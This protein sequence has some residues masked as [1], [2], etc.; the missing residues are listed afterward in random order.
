MQP[1]SDKTEGKATGKFPLRL[2]SSVHTALSTISSAQEK[3]L[4]RKVEEILEAAMAG[5]LDLNEYK[6]PTHQ[7]QL[8]VSPDVIRRFVEFAKSLNRTVNGLARCAIESEIRR[9]PT[10]SISARLDALK[11]KHR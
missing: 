1:S 11:N 3:T 6:E 9:T 7:T 5:E 4:T 8:G 2:P 10:E